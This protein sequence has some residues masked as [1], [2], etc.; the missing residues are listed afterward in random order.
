MANIADYGS[1]LC[2]YTKAATAFEHILPDRKLRFSPYRL[3]RDPMESKE[4]VFGAA[5]YP[6]NFE[7]QDDEME[8]L[9][10]A[11][12]AANTLKRTT[13]LLALTTDE[14]GYEGAGLRDELFA[15]G[16]A[17]A[18][19]WEL[20]GE[21]HRGA[22]LVFDRDGLHRELNEGLPDAGV[23]ALYRGAVRYTH[24][25]LAGEHVSY[26]LDSF[27]AKN[28]SEAAADFLERH[29]RELF[30][31]KT[32]DWE[33]EHEYRYLALSKGSDYLFAPFDASLKA[34][35]V[36]EQCPRWQW[37]GVLDL[38]EQVG[39]TA[40][41]H[42]RDSLRAERECRKN[43]TSARRCLRIGVSAMGSVPGHVR[44]V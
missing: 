15:R 26:R 34:V 30:L 43:V 4:W 39:A 33:S 24:A 2:H 19:M 37:P 28:P 32:L 13:K 27:K 41:V 22:C 29:H 10:K 7:G 16:W 40:R 42:L 17:R 35:V 18:R 44:G 3:M 1:V 20:Y 8:T 21:T 11:H 12:E 25:G 31:L 6:D 9:A 36:G 23:G 5:F 38:S 14:E